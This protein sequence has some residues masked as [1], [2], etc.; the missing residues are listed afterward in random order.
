[1]VPDGG[2]GPVSQLLRRDAVEGEDVKLA[3]HSVKLATGVQGPRAG[4][5][6]HRRSRVS[7]QLRDGSVQRGPLGPGTYSLPI[8]DGLDGRDAQLQADEQG[9]HRGGSSP[10]HSQGQSLG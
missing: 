5:T 1:M 3:S 4:A 6:A 8:Q 10:L 2:H 9:G 7:T